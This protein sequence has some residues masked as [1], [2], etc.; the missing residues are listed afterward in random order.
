M[1]K[2][3]DVILVNLHLLG[4]RA[5]D[6]SWTARMINLWSWT[7]ADDGAH[8]ARG[9]SSL[10]VWVR[11][12]LIKTFDLIVQ[13]LEKVVV[14]ILCEILFLPFA[15]LRKTEIIQL[16]EANLD[17][18]LSHIL[19]LFSFILI[20]IY[21]APVGSSWARIRVSI[22]QIAFLYALVLEVPFYNIVYDVQ[23]V[24]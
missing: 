2:D 10:F 6:A 21:F 1:V 14:F 16:F 12:I 11:L 20:Y 13:K 19:L 17:F 5:S 8:V 3:R 4:T 23:R 7:F 15:I 24:T 18:E 9:F 22:E